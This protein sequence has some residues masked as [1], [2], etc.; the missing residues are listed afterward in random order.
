MA[1]PAERLVQRARLHC[2][3]LVWLALLLAGGAAQAA[4]SPVGWLGPDGRPNVEAQQAVALLAG[5]ASHGLEPQ[6]YAVA[7]LQQAVARAGLSPSDDEAGGRQLAR[8]LSLAMQRYL[9]DLHRGRVDP[10]RI[11][12]GFDA[13]RGDGFDAAARLRAALRSGQL[14]QAAD[15]A[16]PQMP[17]YQQLRDALAHYRSLVDHAAWQ[18]P[19]PTLP[20]A[21]QR[22][23]G[24]LEPGQPYAGLALLAERLTLLGDLP[25]GTPVPAR[26]EGALVDAV[27]AFQRRHGLVVDGVVGR[28]TLAQLQVSPS[29]R[30]RQIELALERLRWTP[31]MQGP[32]MVVINIPEF[33]LR[34]YEVRDGRIA[35]REQM[36]VIVGKS[37]DTRTPLFDEDMRFIEFSPYW[38]V[39]FSIARAETV[40]R[41]RREPDHFERQGFE[42]VTRDGHVDTTLS[43]AKLEAVL[44]GRLRIRQR[45]GPNNALGDIKFIFPNHDNIYLHHTPATGLFARERRD[46]SHGCIRVEQP[47]ALA[48]F[49]LKGMPGW[50]EARIR[51]AMDAGRSATLRL[52]KPVPV[53]IAYGTALVKGGRIHFFDDIYGLDPVLDAALRER[54]PFRLNLE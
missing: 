9:G 12:H 36:K 14:E 30:V 7:E 26:Y 47:V 10:R 20:D 21:T 5:A 42:F 50:D 16:A 11:Q 41:L 17:M 35:V 3:R 34:A 38:N 31:L 39:P 28:A 40:P 51:Q 32:R 46:F 6:D 37:F 2:D 48:G 22:G 44:A 27:M 29:A 54:P 8:G 53:L 45:P 43:E 24:K 25:A 1:D 18:P 13:S 49:V 23:V 52:A 15:A 4:E 19:L 33:M